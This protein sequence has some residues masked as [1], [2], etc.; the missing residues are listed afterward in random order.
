MFKIGQKVVCVRPTLSGSLKKNEIYTITW[1]GKGDMGCDAVEVAETRPTEGMENFYSW[2]FRAIDDD[3]V[4][5]VLERINADEA[6]P[7]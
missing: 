6:V 2:R 5:E 4:D 3:W 1:V 7:A